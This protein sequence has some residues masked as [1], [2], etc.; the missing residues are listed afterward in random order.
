MGEIGLMG[1]NVAEQ[2]GGAELD[3]L[4]YAISCE[5]ISR[6]CASAGVILSAHNSLYI[7]PIKTYGNHEQKLKYVAPFVTG[8][9]HIALVLAL[10]RD[11]S[12]FQ[13]PGLLD[14]FSPGTTGPSRSLGPVLSRPGTFPGPPGTEQS[15]WKA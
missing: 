4:A 5:E 10:S 9:Y 2:Y 13:V 14:F 15:C 6:G 3:A 7:S 1:I 12:N 8:K 11:F